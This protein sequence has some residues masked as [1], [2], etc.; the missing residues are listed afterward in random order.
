MAIQVINIGSAVNAGD[1]DP[2]RTAFTKTNENF[3]E[4]YAHLVD[5]ANPHAVTAEETLALPLSGGT[6]D[7]AAEMSWNGAA[8]FNVNAAEVMRMT[9]DIAG[10]DTVIWSPINSGAAFINNTLRIEPAGAA[11]KFELG[12]VFGYFEM[13]PFAGLIKS[14]L[15][16]SLTFGVST[17][18]IFTCNVTRLEP[19]V[20][21]AMS[22]GQISKRWQHAYIMNIRSNGTGVKF[23]NSTT[24]KFGFWNVTP[25]VQPAA[26]VDTLGAS[27][28][29]LET[30]VN[31]L[32]QLNR[33]FGIMAT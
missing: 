4:L 32:K 17:G 21:D 19:T 2:L 24:E 26:I 29:A 23:G 25:I 3:T 28:A 12:D 14:A 13:N 33:D 20:D 11:G 27:L 30:E 15:G 22:L 31:K 1:G 6:M 16:A 10:S 18:N 8:I 7:A 9:E 5:F